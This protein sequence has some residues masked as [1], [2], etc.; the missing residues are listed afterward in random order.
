MVEQHKREERKHNIYMSQ[1]LSNWF[2]GFK[3]RR[4]FSNMESGL[5]ISDGFI[6]SSKSFLPRA[7]DREDK[8]NLGGRSPFGRNYLVLAS[9]SRWIWIMTFVIR[10]MN[11]PLDGKCD[12]VLLKFAL[13][14]HTHAGSLTHLCWHR[15]MHCTTY[16]Q[17]H[18]YLPTLTPTH[19][20]IH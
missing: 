12:M 6:S 20:Y 16:T 13:F 4:K 18:V 19:V 7:L 9:L 2:L 11:K 1:L 3:M 15:Q 10:I 14:T 17:A 8:Y 5:K